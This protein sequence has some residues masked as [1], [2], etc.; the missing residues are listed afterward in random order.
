MPVVSTCA[1]ISRSTGAA[2]DDPLTPGCIMNGRAAHFL[3][4]HVS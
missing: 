1:W 2:L 3:L 4:Q